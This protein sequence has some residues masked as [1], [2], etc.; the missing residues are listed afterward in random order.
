MPAGVRRADGCRVH[1]PSC[2][3]LTSV[4]DTRF[5]VINIRLIDRR[6]AESDDPLG[7]DW[8]GYDP[9]A[10]PEQLWAHNRGDWPLDKKRIA[11]ERWAA[12]SYRGRI[13]L[14][15]ELHGPDHEILAANRTGASK[16]ALIGRPLS[17]GHLIH[18]A[19]IGTQVESRRNPISYDLDP[20]TAAAADSGLSETW[21]APGMRGQGLQMDDDVRRAIENAARDRLMATTGTAAG[22]S[23]IRGRIV[24]TMPS[25]LGTRSGSILK[26][27]ALRA[28][29]IRSSSR[30]M[31]SITPASIRGS[32]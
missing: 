27:K 16:K 3:V 28:E 14:V 7:C 11:S 23:Q 4:G 1:S 19:L 22:P 12:L 13:V 24:P 15:A 25:Q 10:T 26:R 32:A 2:T 9:D 30:A 21:D 5:M 20:E 29:G 18:E 8:W 17:A 6:T 31:R